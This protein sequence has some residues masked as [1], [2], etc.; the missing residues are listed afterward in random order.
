MAHGLDFGRGLGMKKP[1]LLKK[2]RLPRVWLFR[3]IKDSRCYLVFGIYDT[4][5]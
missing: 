2:D 1:V 3:G 4:S 5:L